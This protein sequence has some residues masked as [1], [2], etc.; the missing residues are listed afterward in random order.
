MAIIIIIIV[1]IIQLYGEYLDPSTQASSQLW[2]YYYYN[3]HST[4]N[5]TEAW[6]NQVIY[7]EVL[8]PEKTAELIEFSCKVSSSHWGGEMVA[9]V[10]QENKLF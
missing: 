9:F 4:Q 8:T 3:L 5:K 6:W 2:S 10:F 7:S 1:I